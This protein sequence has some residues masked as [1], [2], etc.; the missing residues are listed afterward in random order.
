MSDLFSIWP[1]PKFRLCRKFIF[2]I[3]YFVFY[4]NDTIFYF[5]YI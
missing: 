4:Y 1:S 5:Y 2:I 3:K